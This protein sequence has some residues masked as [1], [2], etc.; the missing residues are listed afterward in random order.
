MRRN[1]PHPASASNADS[2]S[3][4]YARYADL[5][6]ILSDGSGFMNLGMRDADDPE[7]SVS[8]IQERLVCRVAE[9]AGLKPIPREQ[10]GSGREDGLAVL[11]VGCGFLGPSRMMASVFGCRVAGIDPGTAQRETWKTPAPEVIVRPCA[12]VAER[13][14]FREGA[15]DR[16]ISIESAFHYPDK[17]A[18]FREACRVLK[19]GG[20]FIL[21]DILHSPA[22]GIA[23]RVSG[24]FGEALLSG[25]FYDAGAY[26]KAAEAA[27]LR[28][29]RFEDLSADVSRTLPVWS[30]ALFRR[31]SALRQRYPAIT[32]LKIGL[33]L[34]LFPILR[35]FLGFQYGLFVFEPGTA[36]PSEGRG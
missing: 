23:G 22:A 31:W 9:A 29:V 33:A 5:F 20:R 19:P 14:P 8:V 21:A 35:R 24:L 27:G 18:F 13:I 17:P 7:D 34:R 12:A 4:Y 25:G 26:E 2:A 1:D 32:L 11:D 6:R 28:A 15:F 30:G 3:A 16:V 10:Q 36:G